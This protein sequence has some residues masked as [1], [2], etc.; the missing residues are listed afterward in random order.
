MN[1]YCCTENRRN[2]IKAH[3]A[4]N[5]I[6][7]LEVK[8]D[9]QTSLYIYFL[10]DIHINTITE[11][12]IS[13]KG[14]ERI[15]KINVV[16]IIPW[17]ILATPPSGLE[18]AIEIKVEQPGDFSTYTLSLVN[19][20]ND[21]ETEVLAG[22]DEL[23]SKV[24]F[25]FKVLCDDDFDCNDKIICAEE[26]KTVPPQ[27]NYL[28]K[29]YASFRQLMLDRMSLLIPDW[30]EQNPSD[31]GIT[32][33]ELLAY[34]ADYLSYRQ[35]ALSTEAYL[36]TARKRISVGRHARLADYYIH[37]GCN[38]RAWVHI[39]VGGGVLGFDLKKEVNG[40][41]TKFL[42]KILD[43][44]K[45]ITIDSPTYTDSIRQGTQVFEL[46]H[47]VQLNYA[48]NKMPF[49]TYGGE[50]CILSKGAREA[51]LLGHYPNLS[52]GDILVLSETKGPETG[53]PQ[54][55]NPK[56][57]HVVRLTNVTYTED[58]NI[59]FYANPLSSPPGSPPE[60]PPQTDTVAITKIEWHTEDALPF[61]LCISHKE[62]QKYIEDVSVALGNIAL[63]DHGITVRDSNET[64]LHPNTVP[65][66]KHRYVDRK[67]KDHCQTKEK[68]SI[69][70]RFNPILKEIPLTFSKPVLFKKD[71][72]GNLLPQINDDVS[73]TDLMYFS[74]KKSVPEIILREEDS[75]LIWEPKSD[76]L[77]DSS[78]NDR[79]FVVEME[80]DGVAHVRFGNDLNGA[81]P[82][83]D[84][85]FLA[86][87]RLGN[88]KIGNVG[89]KT[90]QHIVG[91]SS[92]ITALQDDALKIW[93][94]LPAQ[95]G[96]EAETLEEVKQYAP[97]AFRTQERAVIPKDYE[98]FAQKCKRDV[99]RATSTFRWTGSWRTAFVTADRFGG[100]EVDNVFEKELRDCL[101]KYRMA[102]FDLEIDSPVPV[103]IE[104]EM[105][106]CIK[107]NYF[108]G[109]IKEILLDV[110]SNRVLSN[111][112]KGFFHPDNFSFGQPLYLSSLYAAAQEVQGV[113]TVTITKFY[114]QN[115]EVSNDENIDLGKLEFG[116][117]EIA[118]LDNNPNFKERGLINFEM[119]GGS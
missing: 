47:D 119:K 25:S 32:L 102:G 51:T 20:I 12:N 88:G 81:R 14:G 29:D 9:S 48:H 8:D 96:Q 23:L 91:D 44:P 19:D 105:E 54:D 35:D 3:P 87:Y 73:A 84:I 97:E 4:L 21:I 52:I 63:V 56:H 114:R 18:K 70:P 115:D 27:I 107:P 46:M 38:A 10:K 113:N 26:D 82:N 62:D 69:P 104:I 31:L 98:Y 68:K 78:A 85:R 109:G 79:H 117:Q 118:Q 93:N 59:D 16:E 30:K 6:D 74:E 40:N 92:M 72:E 15:D 65:K 53:H 99:Q 17:A 42:T 58:V 22:F 71:S 11:N 2:A 80:S 49:Y 76:L 112:K 39:H 7:F 64:S 55:A 36:G 101:E 45:L 110:F 60:S 90:I 61:T 83:S 5:G 28:A 75:G 106:I 100:K 89:A 1:Y 77:I 108:R 66:I 57:N 103:S 37:N 94:P 95:G 67:H 24:D 34:T 111:G 43:K 86:T 50:G 33:V 41:R 116:R 13:I